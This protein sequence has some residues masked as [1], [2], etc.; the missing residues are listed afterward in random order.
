MLIY[1]FV[2][3]PILTR[4]PALQDWT[5]FLPG[6]A[7]AALTRISQVGQEFL[8]P[9]QGGL[10]LAGYAALLALAAVIFAVRRDVT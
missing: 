1:L 3:E 7:S 10:V 4:I 9:W 6:S 8:A 5:R 2:A